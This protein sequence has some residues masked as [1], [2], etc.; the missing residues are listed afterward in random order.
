MKIDPASVIRPPRF[1]YTA[2]FLDPL[3]TY[4]A[5]QRLFMR[6]FQFRS[7][8]V[9]LAPLADEALRGTREKT[10]GTQGIGDRILYREYYSHRYEARFVMWTPSDEI[11]DAP[12]I[13]CNPEANSVT[14]ESVTH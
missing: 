11:H 6:G 2:K 9:G 5:C 13:P 12:F 1:F 14:H 7:R 4:P 3:V 8:C 10:S